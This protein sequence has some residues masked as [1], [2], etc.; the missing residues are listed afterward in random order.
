[1]CSVTLTS[2]GSGTSDM[3]ANTGFRL[4][5]VDGKRS[6]YHIRHQAIFWIG[7]CQEKA[8]A[9]QDSGD[10]QSWSPGTLQPMGY[11]MSQLGHGCRRRT[12]ATLRRRIAMDLRLTHLRNV[13]R[14]K[15]T[16]LR[17]NPLAQTNR[18]TADT[19]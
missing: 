11:L 1:M 14:V 6:A 19:G 2:Q 17:H 7:L 12:R 16:V 18:R 9:R 4:M 5:D 8:Y 13:V 15:S 10:V 3:G